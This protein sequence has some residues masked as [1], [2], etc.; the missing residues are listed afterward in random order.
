MDDTAV[1]KTF[2]LALT[3]SGLLANWVLAGA[4]I[5]GISATANSRFEGLWLRG[6]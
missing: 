4:K 1:A 2:E 5:L 6:S 3:S